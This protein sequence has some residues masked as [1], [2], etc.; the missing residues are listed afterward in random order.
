[1]EITQL[2]VMALPSAP[3]SN[4]KAL[5]EDAAIYFV[6]DAA[7]DIHYIGSTVNLKRRFFGHHRGIDFGLAQCDRVCF[8]SARNMT[9]KMLRQVEVALIKQFQPSLNVQH[10]KAT[11]PGTQFKPQGKPD[12]PLAKTPT[13]TKHYQRVWKV[14]QRMDAPAAY[15]RDAVRA[16]MIEDGLISP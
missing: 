7:G 4:A 9:N 11:S 12:E 15:I 1:M 3:I 14:L 13:N 2:E 5:P 6:L 10:L 8:L 16:K